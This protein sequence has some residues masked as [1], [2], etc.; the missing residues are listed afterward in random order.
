MNLFITIVDDYSRFTWV[1]F[2]KQKSE[3]LSVFKHFYDYVLTQFDKRIKSVRT[4]NA[5]ELS[6]GD[7]PKICTEKDIISQSSCVDTPQQNEVVERKH[8]H[9]LE[10]TRALFF[11]SN[12]PL[13]Y[14]ADC[15]MCAAHII[16]RMPLKPIRHKTP[17]EVLQ[18]IK[19]DF[20]M[21]K[22]FGCLCF[23]STLRKDRTKIDAREEP[24]IFIGYDLNQKEY[25]LVNLRTRHVFLFRDVHFH[26][27]SFP[28]HFDKG[29][30][31]ALHQFFYT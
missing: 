10:V 15:V 2:V 29:L 9:L 24:C 25:K 31:K 21:L 28:Y 4:D 20:S 3:F 5:K 16:N 30:N 27:Q 8:K 12:L 18:G 19:P 14:W 13:H 7:T 22:A 26:E 11:Q 6:Q 1:F 17:Y 23:A